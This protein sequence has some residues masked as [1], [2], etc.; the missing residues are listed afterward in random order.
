MRE[1]PV[2]E[3]LSD[4]LQFTDNY[5]IT[6]ASGDPP[7]ALGHPDTDQVARVLGHLLDVCA[8]IVRFTFR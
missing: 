1:V 7:D 6:P 3:F 4:L 8:T 5:I 2:G